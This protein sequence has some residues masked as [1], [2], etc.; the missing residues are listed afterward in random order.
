MESDESFD[1]DLEEDSVFEELEIPDGNDEVENSGKSVQDIYLEACKDNEVFPS[2]RFLKR[3]L[4][5]SVDLTL[6]LIHI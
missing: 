4:T 2:S 3:C 6:S 1:T 5:E